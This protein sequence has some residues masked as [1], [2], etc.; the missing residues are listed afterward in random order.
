MNHEIKCKG[1]NAP[2]PL[3]EGHTVHFCPYCGTAVQTE[4]SEHDFEIRK[5]Q[6]GEKIRKQKMKEIRNKDIYEDLIVLFAIFSPF[7][8]AI[9]LQQLG[10]I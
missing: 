3:T 2:I 10:I 8:F 5:M 7:L 1:C 4:E 6:L 9:I